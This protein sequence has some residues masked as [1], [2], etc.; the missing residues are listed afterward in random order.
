VACRGGGI[1]TVVGAVRAQEAAKEVE[2]ERRGRR[3]L[4]HASGS[5]R[6]GARAGGLILLGTVV[7]E[8]S[9]KNQD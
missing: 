4:R 7:V 3:Q 8:W 6:L 1:W 9:G 2:R 5:A